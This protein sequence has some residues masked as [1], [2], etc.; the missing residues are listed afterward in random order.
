MSTDKQAKIFS[1]YPFPKAGGCFGQLAHS[2]E[3]FSQSGITVYYLSAKPFPLEENK[4]IVYYKFPFHFRNEF[5]FYLFFYLLAPFFILRIIYSNRIKKILIFNEEFA[6]LTI[7]A[8]IFCNVKIVLLIEGFMMSF[9]KSRRFNFLIRFLLLTYGKLGVMVS[10]KILTVSGDLREKIK[11][12]YKT[13]KNI[14]VFYNYPLA[15]EINAAKNIN[16][17]DILN[18]PHNSFII[19]GVGSLILRKNFTYLMKE[20]A[21]L[22][23]LNAHLVIVGSGPEEKVLKK[24]TTDL[25]I[26]NKVSF[27]GQRKDSLDI[28]KSSNLL[29]LPTLHDDCPLVIIESLQLSTACLAAKRGGIPEVLKYEE[30]MFN[31]DVNGELTKKLNIII[32]DKVYFEKIKSLCNQRSLDF[33]K[34]WKQEILRLIG[35]N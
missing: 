3:A 7:L 27:L 4:N 30:L 26:E 18:L 33:N 10:D 1:F 15:S 19:T 14:K 21:Q 23:Q 22:K 16:L 2:I 9:A 5:I 20:F 12:L 24:L 25:K 29:I 32:K 34:D 35:E 28:I 13:D 8:K 31:V 17:K 6:A 11:K